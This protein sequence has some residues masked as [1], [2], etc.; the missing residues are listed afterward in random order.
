MFFSVC[1]AQF[2]YGCLLRRGD[3][4]QKRSWFAEKVGHFIS[5]QTLYLLPLHSLLEAAC[6][7]YVLQVHFELT[8]FF[9]IPPCWQLAIKFLISLNPPGY[10]A[11][12]KSINSIHMEGIAFRAIF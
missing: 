8:H 4:N 7:L 11:P 3:I 9:K 12:N 1:H 2:S 5:T 6:S 10:F